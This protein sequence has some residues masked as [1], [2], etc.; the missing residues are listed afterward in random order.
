MSET[1]EV[2]NM[3]TQSIRGHYH[4][5]AIIP[6]R[7]TSL[8]ENMEVTILLVDQETLNDYYLAETADHRFQN[9]TEADYMDVD[10]LLKRA[11][12]GGEK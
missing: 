6:E 3:L 9:S 1:T 10:E 2:S 12:M 4:N 5:G 11:E 8:K 7:S